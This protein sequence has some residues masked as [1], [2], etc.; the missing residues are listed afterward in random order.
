M[1]LIEC[2]ITCKTQFF[3]E[4]NGD[5]KLQAELNNQLLS[6]ASIPIKI[7]LCTIN[8]ATFIGDVDRATLIAINIMRVAFPIT[9]LLLKL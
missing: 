1:C 3:C 8:W 2:I 9:V 4:S 5:Q 6:I 7:A